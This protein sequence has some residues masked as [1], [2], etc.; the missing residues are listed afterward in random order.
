V[1]GGI[2]VTA[3]YRKCPAYGVWVLDWATYA[4]GGP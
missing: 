4:T 1:L 3:T 2:I